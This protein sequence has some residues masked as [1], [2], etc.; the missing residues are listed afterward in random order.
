MRI[1]LVLVWT[2]GLALIGGLAWSAIDQARPSRKDSITVLTN[3]EVRAEFATPTA[4]RPTPGA[5]QSAD[6]HNPSTTAIPLQRTAEP[7]P[8][9]APTVTGPPP[10]DAT[11]TGP[12]AVSATSATTARPAPAS[13]PSSTAPP[14]AVAP[15]TTAASPTS[16][17]P[18]SWTT[19]PGV[20][21][22]VS[23][24]GTIGVRCTD[25]S[26]IELV[27]A[28]PKTGWRYTPSEI[29][30]SHVKVTFRSSTNYVEVEAECS[31]GRVESSI[32]S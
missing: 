28:S 15:S 32:E 22:I 31:S 24:G 2:A 29:T 4:S 14:T 11:T 26:H 6:S 17:A 9:A 16:T 12:A 27:Y 1:S 18:A 19:A 30:S 7:T 20:V 21:A 10:V 25:N 23:S 8:S 13:G 5:V 3:A